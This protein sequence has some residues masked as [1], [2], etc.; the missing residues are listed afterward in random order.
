MN[1][2][3]PLLLALTFVACHSARPSAP[4]ASLHSISGRVAGAAGSSITVALSGGAN[5][6]TST[7][8]AGSFG[9]GGLSDGQ[10]TLTPAFQGR[11]FDPASRS[12]DLVGGDVQGI[13]FAS[14]VLPATIAGTVGGPTRA[15]VTVALT[16]AASLTTSTDDAGGYVFTALPAGSYLVTPTQSGH[17]LIP[18]AA[19]IELAGVDRT[20][21]DFQVH[22]SL[23]SDDGWCWENPLPQGNRLVSAWGSGSQ[24]VWAVGEGGTILHWDGQEWSG[25]FERL[26]AGHDLLSGVSGSGASDV[27]LVGSWRQPQHWD[28]QRWSEAGVAQV[29]DESIWALAP[30]QAWAVG[31]TVRRW[32]GQSWSDMGSLQA[33]TG[34]PNAQRPGLF[35]RAYRVW[36]TGP[37]DV[38]I[39]GGD[40]YT[41]AGT[42]WLIHFD[43]TVWTSVPVTEPVLGLWGSS[44][45]DV[46]VNATGAGLLHLEG[47]DWTTV[48]VDS[49]TYLWGIWGTGAHDVW[50]VGWPGAVR[51]FDGQSWSSGPG[52]GDTHGVWGAAGPTKVRVPVPASHVTGWSAAPD[53]AWMVGGTWWD[54]AQLA[55]W[56][57]VAWT[58]QQQGS[59]ADLLT[60]SVALD[61]DAWALDAWGTLLHRAGGAWLPVETGSS[62]ALHGLWGWGRDLA[63]AVGDGGTIL[64]WNGGAWAPLVSGTPVNLWAVWGSAPDDVWASGDGGTLLHWDGSAWS[65]VPSGSIAALVGLSGLPGDHPQVACDDGTVLRWGGTGYAPEPTGAV[66]LTGLTVSGPSDTFA[67]GKT[68][69]G[70][71]A[72]Y[73]WDGGGWSVTS[74]GLASA[75]TALGGAPSCG[76]RAVAYGQIVRWDGA[77]WIAEQSAAQTA[78]LAIGCDGRGRAFAVGYAGVVL[79]RDL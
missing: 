8:S 72:V 25:S 64:S 11:K 26:V 35:P 62:S 29:S 36:G 2:H 58:S 66:Q 59:N 43:G 68:G 61:G 12:V 53:D 7:D 31:G 67:F 57:G 30:D 60:L 38:W 6:V 9:F 16:G 48:P 3:A 41:Q 15:G 32:D 74:T 21:V 33:L 49:G 10:Y 1:R 56:D 52:A 27:W 70:A 45:S 78:L 20:G 24:D 63:F 37:D 50:T 71:T 65:P 76:V 40:I 28:G 47:Q 5:L 34:L 4:P 18:E 39:G 46:W 19:A 55:H 79:R 14:S 51:H 17:A 42:G 44:S 77:A 69:S 73:R 54:G 22:R 75:V 13:T 23:C